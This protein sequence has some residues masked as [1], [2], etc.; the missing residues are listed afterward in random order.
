M[1]QLEMVRRLVSRGVLSPEEALTC[2]SE[3]P[4][5]SLGRWPELGALRAGSLADLV[6]LGTRDLALERVLVGGVELAPD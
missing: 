6:V 4:A 3:A 2:A 1:S 5:R